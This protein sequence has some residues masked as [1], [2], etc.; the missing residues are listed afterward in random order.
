MKIAIV[1]D[2]DY[3]RKVLERLVRDYMDRHSIS[4]TITC[5]SGGSA[6]LK[7]FAPG[8]FEVIFLDQLMGEMSGMDTARAL[9]G[10]DTNAAIIF[11]T[12]EP[13]FALEGYS[14]QAMDYVIK[15]AAAGRVDPILTRLVQLHSPGHFIDV[16]ENRMPRRIMLDDVRYVRSMGHF[17][18]LHTDTEDIKTYM[19]M[20]SLLTQL[21]SM[22][23]YGESSRG[24]RFQNCCRGYLVSLSHVKSLTDRDFLMDDGSLVPISRPKMREMR[25][26]YA[27]WLFQ[28]SRMPG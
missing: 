1:D 2:S 20:D 27:A 10:R 4:C 13:G 17:L 25:G 15:P 18:N 14:V 11:V 22:G 7:S 23:E 6:F 9:R 28:K 3:D 5:Y 19:S 21:Q 24:L 12:T 26:A 16:T 8:M